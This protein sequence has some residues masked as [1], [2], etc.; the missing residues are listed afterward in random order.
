MKNNNLFFKILKG[1]FKAIYITLLF[2]FSIGSGLAIG[3]GIFGLT[4][5]TQYQ[6]TTP[7]LDLSKLDNP[8]ASKI[9]TQDG[10]L[11]SEIG[12]ENR[13]EVDIRD[14]PVE[15]IEALLSTEDRRF[16]SHH[17]FDVK[18]TVKAVIENVK[19]GFGS[20]G[21]ST[22]TQQL[23]KLTFLDPNESSLKRKTHELTLAWELEDM[24]D[25]EEILELYANKIYMGDGVY[26]IQ[27]A[28]NHFYGKDL[29]KLTLPQL[30]LLA[31]I[32]NAPNDYNPYDFPD[33]ALQRRNLVLLSML[34]NETI[35]QAEYD[36]YYDVP[37]TEGLLPPEKARQSTMNKVPKE[38]QLYVDQAINEVKH[39]L[40]QD[41]YR[42]GLI[43]TIA[44]DEDLQ[45]FSNE[46]TMTNKYMNYTNSEM[47]VNFTII[48]NET[49]RVLSSGSGNRE[50]K[51]VVDG[52]NYTTQA[53]KQAG[54]TMKPLLS[55]APAFEYLG[56]TKDTS[57]VDEP[58]AYSDG[59]PVYNWD[60]RYQG[61][62]SYSQALASSRNIPALKLTA[63]VG[64]K[65]AYGFANKLGMGFKEEDFVE[66]G[67]LGSVSNS[68]PYK[69]A[70]AYSAF[71]RKG[72]FVEGHT[73]IKV[74]DA[75]GKVLYTEPQGKQVMKE[76][77]AKQ[78][79]EMLI[80]TGSKPYGTA[81]GSLETQGNQVAIKTGTTNYGSDE[82]LYNSG[83][84]P[85]SWV[86]G[87]TK[88]YTIAVWQGYDSRNKGLYNYTETKMA[89]TAFNIILKELGVKNTKFD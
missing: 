39:K 30:A 40:K 45:K 77:T 62:M 53:N 24:F 9:V 4:L 48:E 15:F 1:F 84:V 88:D 70:S 49:G 7:E 74:E 71:A 11:L 44:L 69:M 63:E 67:A 81:Y 80:E 42:D 38:Y 68:N 37:L 54:S 25:K 16:Y 61:K 5:F 10:V 89:T 46:F 33:L 32:P 83:M 23:I 21:G 75:F 47:M 29:D 55:Y 14:I 41:P 6:K 72:N 66:S 65:N 59:T 3:G 2:I 34:G 52:F 79:T 43:I 31:G 18:R 8:T 60:M 64:F 17:G 36:E 20:Q 19:N 76:S 56:T 26:G 58:Y 27:T 85:D 28:S 78:I 86:V 57:I 73:V 51:I 12:V 87:Y 50:T 82:D 35:T 22:L 13:K